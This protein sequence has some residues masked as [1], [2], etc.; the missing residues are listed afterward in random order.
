MTKGMGDFTSVFA[1]RKGFTANTIA[2]ANTDIIDTSLSSISDYS[3]N[4]MTKAIYKTPY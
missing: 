4:F 2:Q 1:M 3:G